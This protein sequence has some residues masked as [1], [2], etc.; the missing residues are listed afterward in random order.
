[1]TPL[2]KHPRRAVQFA[3]ILSVVLCPI[4]S[5]QKYGTLA[6]S[7]L[8][9]TRSSIA[10]GNATLPAC[11]ETKA[12]ELDSVTYYMSAYCVSCTAPETLIAAPALILHIGLQNGACPS[13]VAFSF[14]GQ[15][16]SYGS[17]AYIG[18]TLTAQSTKASGR[19]VS[20]IDCNGVPTIT[21]PNGG[22][23]AC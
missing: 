14:T 23:L 6:P 5:A 11:S 12:E 13:P 10:L 7:T 18:G 22:R 21:G 2:E 3:L 17:G 9:C 15:V 16:Y 20:T 4:A 1:M 19:I 8:S